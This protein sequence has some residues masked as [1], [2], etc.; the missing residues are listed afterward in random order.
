MSR[1]TSAAPRP[2][3]L[4]G[5]SAVFAPR[6]AIA[7]SH[8]LAS[9]AGLALLQRGANAVDAAVAAAAVLSVVEPHMTGLGGDLFALLWSAR[10]GELVGLNASGRSGSGMTRD[11]LLARGHERVP[12]RGAE[13]VT[14]PGALSGWAALLA[15]HGTVP[16]SE[17]LQPAIRLA[18]DGFPVSPIVARQWAAETELL[19]QGAGAAATYLIDGTRAPEAGEWFRNPDYA[20]TLRLIAERGPGALYGGELGER[21]AEG[22]RELGGFLT[23]EDLGRH[24]P[25]WVEPFHA[26][27]RGHRVWQLPPNGQGVAALEML[28]LL[29]PLDLASM[30]HNSAE[31]LHHLVEAKKLA[32]ADLAHFVADP[33]HMSIPPGHLL[34]DDFV[35]GRRALL[36]PRRAAERLDPGPALTSS[37][38]VYVAAA[39][40]EGNMVSFINSIFEAFG[41]G[42]VV[43]GTGFALQN[44]GS[45]FSLEA[46]HCNVAAPGKLPFHTLIPGFVTRP[47]ADGRQEP[48][49]AYG[50]MGGSMQPQGHVQL[51]AN[52]LVFGM[53]IQ[54]AIDAPRFRH[55]EGRRLAL[56]AP[57][58]DG[59]RDDLASR[60]HEIADE[61]QVTFGGA[62]AVMRLP[63]GWAAGSDP[64]KDGQAGGW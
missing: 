33:D 53:G 52:L 64:R 20:A 21:L 4:A 31:Y 32:F 2:T 26:D 45:G 44:R 3:T 58:G 25:R 57:I 40:A 61:S 50:V 14:V 10:R 8:P 62:Q 54:E 38:T 63:R 6:A 5:R 29:E 1:S 13:A 36:D 11:E 24:S 49:L 41:S 7:T 30:G 18:R 19:R 37:E 16:L 35:A 46:G 23:P 22:V 47:G 39:D 51:L 17:A 42:V 59:V 27:F 28:R 60:G 55:L 12:S 43:P 48:W 34:G 15:K 56:E 9:A